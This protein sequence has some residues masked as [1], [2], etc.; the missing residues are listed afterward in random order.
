MKHRAKYMKGEKKGE[1][2]SMYPVPKTFVDKLY[3]AYT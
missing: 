1:N 2:N 3:L